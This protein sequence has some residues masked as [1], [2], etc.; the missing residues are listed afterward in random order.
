VKRKG[1]LEAKRYMRRRFCARTT[2][3]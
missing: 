2:P 3:D 1:A